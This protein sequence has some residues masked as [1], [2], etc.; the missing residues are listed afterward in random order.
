MVFVIV[1]TD[2][3]NRIELSTCIEF[4]PRDEPIT[5]IKTT[6]GPGLASLDG[7]NV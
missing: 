4:L 5:K 2:L 3:Q 7:C 6:I 1:V